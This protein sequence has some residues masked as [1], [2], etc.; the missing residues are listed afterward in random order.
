VVLAIPPSH[1]LLRGI[2]CTGTIASIVYQLLPFNSSSFNFNLF[3]QR[4]GF[5][6]KKKPSRDLITM[7]QFCL[8]TGG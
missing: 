2:T 5:L 8:P 7:L 6:K 4:V 3:A 1:P